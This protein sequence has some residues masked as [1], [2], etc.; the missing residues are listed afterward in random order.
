MQ[1]F[2]IAKVERVLEDL[3]READRAREEYKRLRRIERKNGY[4]ASQGETI[5]EHFGKM[6][7]YDKAVKWLEEALGDVG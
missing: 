6:D 3:R 7:A 5:S 2:R 1:I 4:N